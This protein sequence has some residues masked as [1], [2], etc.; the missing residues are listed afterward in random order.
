MSESKGFFDAK[1]QRIVL[2]III[3]LLLCGFG[4]NQIKMSDMKRDLNISRQNEYALAGK[5]AE[6]QTKNDKLEYTKGVLVSKNKDL[7]DLSETLA[8]EVKEEEGKVH[9]LQ[10]IIATMGNTGK[11][12]KVDTLRMTNTVYK[13]PD[14]AYGLKWSD[15]TY[16]DSLNFRLLAGESKFK[17]LDLDSTRKEVYPLSTDL[18]TDVIGFNIITGLKTNKETGMVEIF[19]RSDYPN[20]QVTEM[21][22]AIIDPNKDPV[23]KKFTRKKK[24]TVG[25]YIGVGVDRNLQPTLQ[26]GVGGTYNLFSF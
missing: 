13:Y 9:R 23:I 17:L 2:I 24:F 18:T 11:D 1:K 8:K 6:T 25:P 14:G 15:S 5:V 26:L 19:V 21:E 4:Y 16:H 10:R 20:F 7:A 22:G 3:I 12:G